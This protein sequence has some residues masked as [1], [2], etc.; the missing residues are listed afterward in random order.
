MGLS[1]QI[2][3]AVAGHEDQV[4]AAVDRVGD[5][6]DERTGGQYAGQV[7]QAQDFL[8]SQVEGRTDRTSD[9]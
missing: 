1:E 8:R 3:N 5:L 2:S 6:A 4:K 9:A 7:D